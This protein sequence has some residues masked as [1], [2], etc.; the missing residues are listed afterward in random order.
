MGIEKILRSPEGTSKLFSGKVFAAH[1]A[2]FVSPQYTSELQSNL[3][4][5]HINSTL[6]YYMN[7]LHQEWASKNCHA[8]SSG[9][10]KFSIAR[11][12]GCE[13]VSCKK[14]FEPGPP[15][16]VINNDRSLNKEFNGAPLN[17]T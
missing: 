14:S 16:P 11:R 4:N 17:L 2:S 9:L 10:R 8:M 12:V 6:K 7:I 3:H 13:K 5:L 15:P 1:A